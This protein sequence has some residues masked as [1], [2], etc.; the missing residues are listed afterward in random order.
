MEMTSVCVCVRTG[1]GGKGEEGELGFVIQ[2]C[3]FSMARLVIS[4]S[5]DMMS[6]GDIITISLTPG[7]GWCCCG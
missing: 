3:S 6:A 5:K 1:G 2:S 4:Q 7:G